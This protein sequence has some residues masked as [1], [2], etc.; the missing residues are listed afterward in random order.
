MLKG[1]KA[2]QAAYLKKG[3]L[4]YIGSWIWELI[5]EESTFVQLSF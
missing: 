3:W 1:K 2:K 5:L 4:S